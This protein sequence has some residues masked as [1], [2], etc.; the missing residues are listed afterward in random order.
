MYIYY[1]KE[2][3]GSVDYKT[4]LTILEKLGC[5]IKGISNNKDLEILKIT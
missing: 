3:E 4:N 2:K 5:Y 1:E